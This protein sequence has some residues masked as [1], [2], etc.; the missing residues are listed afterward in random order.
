MRT[1]N[2]DGADIK[3]L[4]DSI[5]D[6]VSL[7]FLDLSRTCIKA[8]PESIT[9]LHNMQTLRLI[10]CASL[11]SLPRN[12]RVLLSLRHI[13]FTYHHQMP[14][15]VG[16]LTSLQ[17][18]PIFVVGKDSDSTI[19]EMESLDGLR[20]LVK[21]T[22]TRR[23]GGGFLAITMGCW[24]GCTCSKNKEESDC[25]MELG[26][27]PLVTEMISVSC[28][29]FG[30]GSGISGKEFSDAVRFGT[31]VTFG[32]NEIDSADAGEWS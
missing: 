7:R 24:D 23:T 11:Q 16:C 3:E 17:T 15:K 12:M 25:R 26:E 31:L 30:A 2:L 21:A 5:G 1:L 4:D 9:D 18:L 20:G 22:R 27:E 13:Y 8:L 19:Q 28:G 10:E 14:V 29:G 6:M 32:I